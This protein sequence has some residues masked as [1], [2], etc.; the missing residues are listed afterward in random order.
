MLTTYLQK[1]INSATAPRN[2]FTS[3]SPIRREAQRNN[4]HNLDE[5]QVKRQRQEDRLPLTGTSSKHFAKPKPPH[6]EEVEDLT[7]EGSQDA[8][9]DSVSVSSAARGSSFKM[10]VLEFRQARPKPAGNSRKRK[11]RAP[12]GGGR[13][14][15]ERHPLGSYTSPSRSPTTE[16]A[17]D[18]SADDLATEDPAPSNVVSDILPR[19]KRG[20][21]SQHPSSAHQVKRFKVRTSQESVEDSA[22][23][24]AQNSGKEQSKSR[25]TNFSQ[26]NP[27]QTQQIKPVVFSRGDIPST[28]FTSMTTKGVGTDSGAMRLRRAVS[29]SNI[30]ERGS[31]PKDQIDLHVGENCLEPK[32]ADGR[33]AIQPWLRC[34]LSITQQVFLQCATNSVFVV[35]KRPKSQR[36]PNHLFLEFETPDGVIHLVERVP[37]DLVQE[38]KV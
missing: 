16:Q 3:S 30:Y 15:S 21:P 1:S 22:D 32:T 13:V 9:Y 37:R 38:E 20:R 35:N 17:S 29:G 25:R 28:K 11:S 6:K 8:T 2:T 31:L 34:D 18:N 33:P 12:S 14:L 5:P 24:L 7:L 36:C 23:E 10:S 26:I 27:R 19:N 4:I